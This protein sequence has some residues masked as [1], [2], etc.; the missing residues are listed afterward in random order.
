MTT[1]VLYIEDD[2]GL[3]DSVSMLL[4]SIDG[5]ECY[6]AW[7][8]DMAFQT[9]D[10]L[11]TAEE[12]KISIVISDWDLGPGQKN[13][14][15]IVSALMGKYPDVKYVIFSGLERKVPQGVSLITKDRLDG[16]MDFVR[17]N[18]NQ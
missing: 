15:E 14:G 7:Y 6:T 12:F 3:R 5:V 1:N 10:D 8:D 9:M 18:L 17:E 11:Q 2:M 4:E 16:L 13:G